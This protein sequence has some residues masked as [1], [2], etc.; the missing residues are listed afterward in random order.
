MGVIP[1]GEKVQKNIFTSGTNTFYERQFLISNQRSNSPNLMPAK[2]ED[3]Q[4]HFQLRTR[5]DAAAINEN[6]LSVCYGILLTGG[7]GGLCLFVWCFCD[8]CLK[9]FFY[10]KTTLS[11]GP[12]EFVIFPTMP[13][14]TRR[15]RPISSTVRHLPDSCAHWSLA[16][17]CKLFSSTIFFFSFQRH[18]KEP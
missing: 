16:L 8:I 13:G 2:I 12:H 9:G 7:G 17:Q 15:E 5:R 10:R 11:Q 14:T 1:R 6:R 4:R 3:V 18:Y